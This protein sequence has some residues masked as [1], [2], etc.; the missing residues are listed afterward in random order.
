MSEIEKNLQEEEQEPSLRVGE[1]I[2]RG[3]GLQTVEGCTSCSTGMDMGSSWK[4]AS[5]GG[6]DYP[7]DPNDPV[8][9][10]CGAGSEN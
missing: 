2:D 8:E 3:N 4:A 7:D 9:F 5:I 10:S 1:F 6:P